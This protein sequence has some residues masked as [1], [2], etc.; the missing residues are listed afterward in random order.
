MTRQIQKFHLCLSATIPKSCLLLYCV[1]SLFCHE[2]TLGQCANSKLKLAPTN[3][4][5]TPCDAVRSLVP[6][7]TRAFE[8]LLFAVSVLTDELQV[9][10]IMDHLPQ[11]PA[12]NRLVVPYY[13]DVFDD[14]DWDRF[15]TRQGWNQDQLVNGDIQKHS[16]ED[17][18]SLLQ[19]WAY[20]GL[21]CQYLDAPFKQVLQPFTADHNGQRNATMSDLR[22][23]L[24]WLSQRARSSDSEILR[25]RTFVAM[26]YFQDIYFDHRLPKELTVSLSI[27][28]EVLS[29]LGDGDGF[30][31]GVTLTSLSEDILA[32]D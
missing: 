10:S 26:M 29:S 12:Q 8:T 16:I 25:G 24:P 6:Y 17:T 3:Q 4:T 21:L 14:G 18:A 11:V 2:F 27:L 28:L 7:S 15:L 1:S 13:G 30:A 9:I 20:Y 5:S 19:A 31:S 23:L 32:M 22:G